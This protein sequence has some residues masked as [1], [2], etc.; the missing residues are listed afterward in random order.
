MGG[1]YTAH[2]L[3]TKHAIDDVV[4]LESRQWLGGRLITT[5]DGEDHTPKF[6]DFAW[7]IG[8]TNA[9]MR[10][11]A[12][13]FGVELVPQTTPPPHAEEA[14]AKKKSPET[15]DTAPRAPDKAP[16]STFS[17]A[18]LEST[19]LADQQDRE[20]GY[21]GRTAQIAFP[22]ETHGDHNWYAPK[23]MN[24]FPQAVARTLPEGMVMT[25][26]RASDV[27]RQEDGTYKVEV[28]HTHGYGYTKKIIRCNHIV[29]AIPP[30]AARTLTV[31]QDMQP[32]LFAVYER[33][34]G[35][36]Y[37]QCKPGTLNVPDTSTGADR[38]YRMV[39]D[40][41]LQQI[42]SGDYGH[43]VFQAGYACDRF[44][45]VWRELEFQG[46][47]A[48]QTEVKRQLAK[49]SGILDPN[50]AESIEKAFVRILF[51]HRW[52]VEAHV[53]GKTKE[54]LSLQAITPNPAKLP[55]LYL[56]GEAYSAQQG[57]TEGA[58]WT[59]SKVA[60]LIS[61]QKIIPKGS[62]D[63]ATMSPYAKP[64]EV[65]DASLLYRGLVLDASSW[66]ELHPGG[67]RPIRWMQGHDVTTMFE[68]Y[69][70]G[71]PVSGVSL[72]LAGSV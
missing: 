5:L 46:P 18:A 43:N 50:L 34:L 47:E 72:D 58:V 48:V 66:P 22:G 41:I 16:L 8:E 4:V 2:Q 20:S 12:K 10:Q 17:A 29:L 25:Y 57:W 64:C 61:R 59:A 65:D 49:L 31:A 37:V 7:R 38:I 27:I 32:A 60:E 9:M 6:N 69:H 30:F 62:R 42:V 19:A 15:W 36:I 53:L 24:E 39:P 23:G 33:R 71:W 28:L 56:V 13:D 51:V 11:I 63:V 55:G 26:H 21:A 67:P 35:H 44:E 68:S 14:D 40:S 70:R 52:Q 45:R 1:L 3:L 54:E